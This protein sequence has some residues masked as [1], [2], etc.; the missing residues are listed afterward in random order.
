MVSLVK[1][2]VRIQ[3]LSLH[4]NTSNGFKFRLV[5]V[6]SDTVNGFDD[7]AIEAA[8]QQVGCPVERHILRKG[9][10][11]LL[12]QGDQ[13]VVPVFDDLDRCGI[14][15]IQASAQVDDRP[16]NRR[17]TD[18][19]SRA[20]PP[21]ENLPGILERALRVILPKIDPMTEPII[22]VLAGLKR[23]LTSEYALGHNGIAAM[24]PKNK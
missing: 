21:L 24:K 14:Q 1:S 20:F 5:L 12:R 3:R 10:L 16:H 9:M 22:I 2:S 17:S 7:R 13:L 15:Q 11:S 6:G 19:V 8:E 4:K 18:L 23:N